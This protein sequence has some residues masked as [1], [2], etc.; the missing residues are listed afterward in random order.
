VWYCTVRFI[1]TAWTNGYSGGKSESVTVLQNS[2]YHFRNVFSKFSIRL[3]YWCMSR[4]SLVNIST[5]YGAGRSR[6]DS[7]E[8][9][10]FFY[11]PQRSH[12][13]WG[14]WSL[15]LVLG[16]VSLGV[17]RPRRE[18]DH[19]SP[20]SAEVKNGGD[21]PPLPNTYSWLCTSFTLKL[22]VTGRGKVKTV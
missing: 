18:A 20:S 22:Q 21:I 8:G 15:R 14:P 1:E 12:C 5:G 17:K 2:L 16:A 13:P 3:Y 4:D 9:R 6:F 10:K 19:S 11:S 7:L